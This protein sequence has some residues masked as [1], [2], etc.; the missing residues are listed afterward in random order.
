ML[1]Q[2]P[3]AGALTAIHAICFLVTWNPEPSSIRKGG[4]T[5]KALAAFVSP[6]LVVLAS[7]LG[8]A[9][10]QLDRP[11]QRL[12]PFPSVPEGT[13]PLRCRGGA[14][15]AIGFQQSGKTYSRLTVA[16]RKGSKPAS[17]GLNPGE[18]P[19]MDRSMRDSEPDSICHDVTDVFLSTTYNHDSRHTP[20]DLQLLRSARSKSAP[21]LESIQEP[22]FNFTLHVKS[23][24]RCLMV[25]AVP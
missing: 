4:M 15:R 3:P 12:Q 18:C 2:T 25:S 24:G 19:W 7:H 22:N 21:Y 13:F 17:K 14:M 16:F 9:Q 11:A 23:E 20:P 6:L 8:I 10:I 1:S 5:M